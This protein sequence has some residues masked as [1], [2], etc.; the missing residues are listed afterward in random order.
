[1]FMGR[2]PKEIAF[3][4][5][6]LSVPVL[7]FLALELV[8]RGIGYGGNR[9]LFLERTINGRAYFAIN[10]D[11]TDRY[12][13]VL[14]VKASLSQ[15]VFEVRK[16]ADTYRV[17]CLG[18]SS[19]LGYP[20]MFNG[21]FPA[22]VRD[23]LETLWPE[24]KFEVINLGITAVNSHTVLDFARDLMN[25]EP[26]ALL[27]YSGHNEFYGALGIGS[28]ERFGKSRWVIQTSLRFQRWRTFLLVRN[29]VA[30][31]RSLFNSPDTR[32]R[33]ATVMEE[34][35]AEKEIVYGSPDFNA[36]V[37]IFH[38][39]L[40]EIAELC[41]EHEVRLVLSTLVSNLSGLPP[42]VSVFSPSTD[43]A[44]R[45][46]WEQAFGE[47]LGLHKQGEYEAALG[48][49]E[50]CAT[51]DSLPARLNYARGKT[52]E[53]K[54][55]VSEARVEYRLARDRDAL[56]FRAPSE[57]N[58][59]IAS[60]ASAYSLPVAP[61]EQMI[62]ERSPNGLIG[63]EFVHEHVHL[64]ID[65]YG[66]VAG[67][68]VQALAESGFIEARDRWH[69]DLQKSEKEYRER[70][71]VTELDSVTASIRLYVLMNS[72]PFTQTGTSVHRFSATTHLEQLAKSVLLR[73]TTWEQAH[74]TLAETYER[75]GRLPEAARE[76]RALR[77]G[78]PH[79]VSPYLREGRLL[80]SLGR[81]RE[82]EE[83]FRRSLRIEPSFIGYQ[84]L[85]FVL[86]NRGD[87]RS[88]VDGFRRAL[89]MGQGVTRESLLET[90]RML[91][92]ALASMGDLAGAT[93]ELQSLLR[94]Q[95]DYRP[96]LELLEQLQAIE[97]KRAN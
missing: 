23:R 94:A 8:L 28:M 56:R 62:E 51:I 13:S 61:S 57:F 15:D 81:H 88:A 90:K 50:Q 37:E 6:L 73:K 30:S 33:D 87:Y 78:T 49:F 44:S 95:P 43:E 80:L 3:R 26:D 16:A 21:S 29:A 66:V 9:D 47:G 46:R 83:V 32:E 67:A 17:F 11:V 22:M 93:N 14:P 64:T 60:V 85:A 74:V 45:G 69:W 42:F 52:Y 18:G 97:S 27:V 53:A 5:G 7:F 91:A 10:P 84:G 58:T 31:V 63:N 86:A 55:W 25:Y 82:A 1:M 4:I 59:V 24:K 92:A 71:G 48:M 41:R 20:T 36:A 38:D 72:W 40:T 54:E 75:E 39:N 12:F 68:F 96:A 77:M 35:V 79:N 2:N 19:T 34:M 65:G 76:Y 89:E 70:V